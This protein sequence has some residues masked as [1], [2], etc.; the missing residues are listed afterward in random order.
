[1]G[2]KIL[3]FIER[4]PPRLFGLWLFFVS[5]LFAGIVVYAISTNRVID[6]KNLTISPPNTCKECVS[7][8]KS[9]AL[10]RLVTTADEE[11][12]LDAEVSACRSELK[13]SL[14]MHELASVLGVKSIDEARSKLKWLGSMMDLSE[15]SKEGPRLKLYLIEGHIPK[16]NGSIST[17]IKVKGEDGRRAVYILI[18]EVLLD[19]GF[20]DGVLD[21]DRESTN[22]ALTSFQKAY[23]A[24][25]KGEAP[26]IDENQF[27]LLGYRTLEALRS[28]YRKRAE[29]S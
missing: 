25:L 28:E 4:I 23:N 5:L 27:G 6:F 20:Y 22:L 18:Q 10:D 16:Y 7:D 1:M 17:K 11:R 2:D 8:D 13:N 3:R 12:S 24:K 19:L 21:G 29:A 9:G 14:Q 26:K 15:F